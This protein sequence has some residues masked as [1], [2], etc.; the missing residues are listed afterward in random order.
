[1]T[2]TMVDSILEGVNKYLLELA[3]EQIKIA[4]NQAEK[5]VKD[6]QQRTREGMAVAKA[7]GKQ[8]G[9]A[10]GTT[11]ETNK[12]KTAKQGILKHS[13]KFY[14]TLNNKEC[15]AM[16]GIAKA[17]FYKY[18]EELEKEIENN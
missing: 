17:T 11:I 3:K 7:N 2:G 9:R 12:A 14:G 4:F 16:L 8:I 15:M 5:E 13:K 10:T 6:L 18:V 1:M